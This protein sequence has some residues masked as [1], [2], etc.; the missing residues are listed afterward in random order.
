MLATILLS[1]LQERSSSLL[2]TYVGQNLTLQF[3]GQLFRHVQKLSLSYHDSAGSSDSTYRIQYDAPAIQHVVVNGVIPLITSAL[4]LVGMF[5]VTVALD[6]QLALVA[7]GVTPVLYGITL[8]YGTRLRRQWKEVKRSDSSAMAV[9]QE[10]L[11]AVRAVK[12]FGAEDCE[13][14]RFLKNSSAALRKQIDVALMLGMYDLLIAATLAIGSALGL[15]VGIRHVLVGTRV[16]DGPVVPGIALRASEHVKQE[17]SRF[18]S[19][20]GERRT[21]ICIDGS[22]T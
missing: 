19:Q 21:G 22:G 11:S 9:V 17:S 2:Q 12:A 20:L 10:V 8:V 13:Q 4:T 18:A 7:I 14:E 5:G 15:F 1:Q 3:R 16:V 6:W